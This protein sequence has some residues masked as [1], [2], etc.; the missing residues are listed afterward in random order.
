MIGPAAS[1][2]ASW[3]IAGAEGLDALQFR[4]R[5]VVNANNEGAMI[6][7]V[8]LVGERPATPASTVQAVPEPAGAALAGLGLGMLAFFGRRSKIACR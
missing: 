1:Q 3:S 5:L 4:F 7:N 8:A 2:L 6:D